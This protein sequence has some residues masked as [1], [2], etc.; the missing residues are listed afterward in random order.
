VYN[1]LPSLSRKLRKNPTHRWLVHLTCCESRVRRRSVP[2]SPPSHRHRSR[3]PDPSPP[4]RLPRRQRP[5]PA[6]RLP[7]CTRLPVSTAPPSRTTPSPSPRSSLVQVL[8]GIPEVEA[9]ARGRPRTLSGTAIFSLVSWLK[10]ITRWYDC[11]DFPN[12]GD[13]Y[14]WPVA[15]SCLVS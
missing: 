6:L 15:C 2:A 8:L 10:M 9:A 14:S 12:M 11:G 1:P 3:C 13:D 4:L 5:A 7:A